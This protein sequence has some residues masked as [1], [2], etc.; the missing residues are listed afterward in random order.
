MLGEPRPS[1]E[2]VFECGINPR[3][4]A[5]D[6]LAVYL[7]EPFVISALVQCNPSQVVLR[8]AGVL[9]LPCVNPQIPQFVVEPAQGRQVALQ[10]PLLSWFGADPVP[11]GSEHTSHHKYLPE[12]DV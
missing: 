4:N 5:L 7:F 12:K 6:D 3:G 2:V 8:E 1:L 9:L 11:E 10:Q